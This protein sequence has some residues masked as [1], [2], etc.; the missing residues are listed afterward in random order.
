[1]TSCAHAVSKSEGQ[2]RQHST[3]KATDTRSLNA[4]TARG[5]KKTRN[6]RRN[7]K[8]IKAPPTAEATKEND[9]WDWPAPEEEEFPSFFG[10][11][12]AMTEEEKHSMGHWTNCCDDACQIHWAMKNA[13]GK[14]PQK[15]WSEGRT[16]G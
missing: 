3:A 4:N 14:W 13:T 16:R 2:L 1:M 8:K 12:A 6:R 11:P 5:P 7:R 9:D 15:P 10:D